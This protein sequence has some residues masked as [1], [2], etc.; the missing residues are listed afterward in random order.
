MTSFWSF[1]RS[2][3]GEGDDESKP[4]PP[5]V[6]AKD[7]SPEP[8]LVDT[9]ETPYDV[10]ARPMPCGTD[11]NVILPPQVGPYARSPVDPPDSFDEP[12][13]A[14]YKGDAGTVFVELGICGEPAHAQAALATAKAETD[15]EFPDNPQVFVQTGDVLCLKTVNRLGAF[16]AWT[17]GPYYF[18][19]HARVEVKTVTELRQSAF[20]VTPTKHIW[21]LM[22]AFYD[23]GTRKK[24]YEAG[25]RISI[26]FDPDEPST[27]RIDSFA[28]MWGWPLLLGLFGATF[29]LF[30]LLLASG[31]LS[32]G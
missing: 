2:I 20:T 26:W 29:V 28:E 6:E 14:T 27:I 1:L 17:R 12:I 22:I 18:S 3:F 13:Y 32:V 16:L 8:A 10:A 9:H 21:T 31:V 23:A 15:A 24:P 19:A 5:S 7:S 25:E 11:L 4:V 30:G